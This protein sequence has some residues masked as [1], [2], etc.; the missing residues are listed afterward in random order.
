MGKMKQN[1]RKKGRQWD[2][3]R[4]NGCDGGENL[5]RDREGRYK[6][7]GIMDA[8]QGKRGNVLAE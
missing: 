4:Q 1:E 3:V 2:R 8:C 5:F 7:A 6:R